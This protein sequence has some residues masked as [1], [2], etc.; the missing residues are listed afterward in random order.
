MNLGTQVIKW[1]I[2]KDRQLLELISERFYRPQLRPVMVFFSHP[3]KWLYFVAPI[4][5]LSIIFG[6]PQLRWRV[7]IIII[8]IAA[9]DWTCNFSKMFFKRIRPKALNHTHGTFG[10]RKTGFWK[11]F[12]LYSFPS[13]HASNNFAL[14]YLICHW[15]PPAG[16]ILY[17]WSFLVAFSR[18]YLKSHYP[19]DVLVGG[20]IGIGYSIILSHFSP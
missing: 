19:L 9:S 15:W 13:S 12:S 17:L 6:T 8:S 10:N 1:V 7:I 14:A 3:P 11:N 20:L 2:N 16:I 4:V 18:V 5:L